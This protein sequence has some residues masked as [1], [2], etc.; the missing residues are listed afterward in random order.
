MYR[1]EKKNI[2]K[3]GEDIVVKKHKSIFSVENHT[4]DF[5]EV[6]YVMSGNGRQ[7]VDG[8]SYNVERGSLLF[9]NYGQTHAFV[10]D[11]EMSFCEI[12]IES[13]AISD[14]IINSENAFEI[15]SL[16]AFED[17]RNADVSSPFVEFSG[18][19]RARIENI[20]EQM[21]W[22]YEKKESGAGTVLRGYLTVLLAYI[23][24]RMLPGISDYGAVPP[25]II[26][27]IGEHLQERLSLEM[28]AK[29]C[30]YS[31]KYFS[32]VFKECYGITVTD[33]IREKRIDE[34]R[35]L[36]TQTQLPVE[37]I[38]EIV[39]YGEPVSF[40]KYFKKICGV[41]PTE[42]RKKNK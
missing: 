5:I 36:L 9:I 23:F 10:S 14:K 32:R 16:T 6:V 17:F 3:D 7:L 41:T 2:F 34:G 20:I 18:A 15:L 21:L 19:E 30:F 38:S 28:L 37:E 1:Y 11:K 4:H 13:E 31:P 29:K 24:R 8:K 12:L 33:Y 27:Y 26:E 39:G 42:Y 22:E 35:R 25:H 40:Y